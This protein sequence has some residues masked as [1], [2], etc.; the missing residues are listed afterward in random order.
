MKY[1]VW[2]LSLEKVLGMTEQNITKRC[3]LHL[4]E[5]QREQVVSIE[6]STAIGVGRVG[7]CNGG[8]K[9]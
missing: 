3:F 8:R 9:R 2:D 6:H 7:T 4:Q 1:V 5:Q